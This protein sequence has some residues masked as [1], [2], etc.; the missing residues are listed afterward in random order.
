MLAR[1]VIN[2]GLSQT[3]LSVEVYPLRLELHLMPKGDR[4]SIRISKKVQ[5]C[6]PSPSWKKSIPT[7]NIYIHEYIFLCR[8]QL[9]N[10]TEKLVK[11][12]ILHRSK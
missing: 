3:D 2:T 11:F 6:S 8:K 5:Q 10:F 4:S 9:E 1:K 12:L 7:L